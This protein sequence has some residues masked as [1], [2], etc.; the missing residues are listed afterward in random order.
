AWEGVGVVTSAHKL[1]GATSPLQAEPD[2]IRVDLA[3]QTERNV[4][5][6]SDSPEIASVK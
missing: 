1:I 6:R 5:H 2:T 3:V 4:V